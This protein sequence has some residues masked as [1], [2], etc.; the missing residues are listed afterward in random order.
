MFLYYTYVARLCEYCTVMRKLIFC[1]YLV[2]LLVLIILLSIWCI[3][4]LCIFFSSSS[5]WYIGIF[6]SYY[7]QALVRYLACP[8]SIPLILR[9]IKQIPDITCTWDLHLMC[10][11]ALATEI[12]YRSRGTVKVTNSIICVKTKKSK[13][14][15]LQTSY[16]KKVK[17]I[18]HPGA[19]IKTLC[20]SL[21]RRLT[22]EDRERLCVHI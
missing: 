6:S 9:T 16:R 21:P 8:S 12:V 13:G 22:Y 2:I 3:F 14:Q 17:V 11:H 10:D 5:S 4:L 18:P 20:L 19:R 15:L 7:I 1:S